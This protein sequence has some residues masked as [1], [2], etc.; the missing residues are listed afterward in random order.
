MQ[1]QSTSGVAVKLSS[2]VMKS[3]DLKPEEVTSFF[4]QEVAQSAAHGNRG[5][6]KNPDTAGRKLSKTERD[7]YEKGFSVGEK[8][9]RM[10]GLRKL[11]PT[12]K[13]LLK[14]IEEVTHLKTQILGETEEDILTIALAIS[15]KII[16]QEVRE[17][18]EI[19]LSN[20]Q[21][22]IK[23]IGKTGRLVIQLHPE[24]L[25]ILSQDAD[26]IIHPQNKNIALQFETNT[27]LSPGDYIVEGEER[28]ID[29]RQ[30]NQLKILEALLRTEDK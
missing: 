15:R 10:L 6:L 26:E 4:F 19:I 28:M 17:N 9:G 20:I 2:N 30:Q 14:L 7:A 22:A 27:G 24:D 18:P 12:E 23:K 8:A 3:D 25:E 11:D 21:Q 1:G 13:I 16:G 5:G 29:G